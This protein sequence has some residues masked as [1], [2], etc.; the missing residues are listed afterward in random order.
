MNIATLYACW[1]RLG[2]FGR[3]VSTALVARHLEAI[4]EALAEEELT[5]YFVSYGTGI[6]Q[7]YANMFPDR[8]GRVIFDGCQ[9][10]KNQRR[11]AGF[12]LASLDNVTDA[13]HK[14]FLGEC[15]EAG[16]DKCALARRSMSTLKELEAWIGKLL[17][18][19]LTQPALDYTA[20]ESPSLITYS[21]LLPSSMV[22]C[23]T[24]GV[25]NPPPNSFPS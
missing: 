8:V 15:V 25:G 16:P 9:Y 21:N 4:R 6:G 10:T 20:T 13:W 12:G 2:D 24:L 7:T 5:A 1:Q 11:L 23:P 3:F 17:E 19:I 22:P 18:S 14:G